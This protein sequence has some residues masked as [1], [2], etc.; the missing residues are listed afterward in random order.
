MEVSV[1]IY[2]L[3][4]DDSPLS[5]YTGACVR[6]KCGKTNDGLRKRVKRHAF[7]SFNFSASLTF[8]KTKS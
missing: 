1:V 8:F 4:S 6:S 7:Y 5:E 3:I 2:N